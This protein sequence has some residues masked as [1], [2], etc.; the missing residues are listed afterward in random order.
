M[1]T[2]LD[3]ICRGA[4]ILEQPR[5]GYRFN[6]DSIILAHFL[7]TRLKKPPSRVI[8][9]G[10]GCGVIGLLL[11]HWWP[12]SEV[13]LIE[14]QEELYGLAQANVHRN[15]MATRVCCRHGDLLDAGLWNRP[16]PDLI[17]CNP[18]FFKLGQGRTSPNPQIAMA[19]HE[20]ACTLAQLLAVAAG[21]LSPAGVLGLIYP[22]ERL[23]ELHL[24][25]QPAGLQLILYRPVIPL[26]D[27]VPSR[28]L[29]L[30]GPDGDNKS[31]YHELPPLIV[32][33]QPGSY[34]I[35]MAQI[36]GDG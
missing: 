13:L 30:L 18:P 27:R 1:G 22:H 26:P 28:V 24:A 31:K 33:D 12:D 35:E 14:L 32:E 16:H 9:L 23:E 17:L 4:L 7:L 3:P 6:V 25:L 5:R 21:A 19:K 2:T 34:S 15:Q 11:A 8:D 20:V 36:L 10:A 29:L